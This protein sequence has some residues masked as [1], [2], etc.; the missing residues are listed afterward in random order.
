M[1]D[2]KFS[3]QTVGTCCKQI[4]VE[5]KEGKIEGVV[6]EGGCHGNLLGISSLVKGMQVTDVIEKLQNI[7]CRGRG[8]SCP[9]QLAIALQSK[10]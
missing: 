10:L 8:T 3:Y 6:F 2:C 1:Q 9:D 5:V 4:Q 7:D